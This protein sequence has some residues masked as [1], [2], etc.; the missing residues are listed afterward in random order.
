MNFEGTLLS[1]SNLEQ[2]DV[3]SATD[4]SDDHSEFMKTLPKKF[5]E[6]VFPGDSASQISAVPSNPPKPPSAG[7][8]KKSIL[9]D[10]S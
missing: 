5:V 6:S 8:L 7:R 3:E 10:F 9:N 4:P 1:R 2:L